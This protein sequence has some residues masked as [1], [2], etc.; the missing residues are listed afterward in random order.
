MATWQRSGRVGRAGRE[1]QDGV[2]ELAHICLRLG[3]DRPTCINEPY[4]KPIGIAW[5]GPLDISAV[6]LILGTVT[7]AFK[8]V[9]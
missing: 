5:G 6:E 9:I 2:F 1:A 3:H 8:A 7:G 4:H